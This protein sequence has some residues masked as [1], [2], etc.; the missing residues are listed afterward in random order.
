MG[1]LF[2]CTISRPIPDKSRAHGCNP[3]GDKTHRCKP[4]GCKPHDCKPYGCKPRARF[5]FFAFS[6]VLLL[7]LFTASC[8]TRGRLTDSEKSSGPDLSAP[9]RKPLSPVVI[10]AVIHGD[11]DYLYHEEDGT[12]RRADETALERTTELARNLERGEVFIFHQKP[13]NRLFGVAAGRE[14]ELWYFRDGRVAGETKYTRRRGEGGL[15]PEMELLES[16]RG[17][18]G[19]DAPERFTALLYFGHQVHIDNGRG[20]HLS[21]QK[22]S[23]TIRDLAEGAGF[24]SSWSGEDRLDLLMLSTCFGG[25]PGTIGSLAPHA[26]HIISSPGS[27]HLSHLDPGYLA[28]AG[29]PTSEPAELL[30]QTARRAFDTLVSSTLTEVTVALYDTDEVREFTDQ[31]SR[32]NDSTGEDGFLMY[33]D[34]AEDPRVQGLDA[35]PGRG[36]TI[37]YRPPRFGRDSRKDTHSGWQCLLPASSR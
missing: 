16:F 24:L 34:L 21:R 36:V 37:F 32:V 4:R 5:F 7:S 19:R 8:A 15:G 10:V 26:E 11:G 30:E 28:H 3:Y 17:R 29:S 13:L 1:R 33:R 31:Y 25:M 12:P 14:S 20:Y 35:E 22:S 9:E 6:A 23:F 27:L 2:P 18:P